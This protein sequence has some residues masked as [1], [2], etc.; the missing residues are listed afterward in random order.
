MLKCQLIGKAF[1]MLC[2]VSVLLT[3]TDIGLTSVL[4]TPTVDN[5]S[6]ENPTGLDRT[7]NHTID[8]SGLT[9]DGSAGST[10]DQGENS[11]VWTTSGV[12]DTTDYD[13]YITYDLGGLCDVTKMRIW[14]YNS[15]Y[16]VGSPPVNITIIGPNEVDVY[17][18]AN[19][20]SFTFAETVNFTE[21]SGTSGYP[22]QDITVDY[23]SVRYIKFDIMTNHDGAVFDGTGSN[24][25]A[26]DGRSLTGLSEVRFEALERVEINESD[27][28]TVVY[29]GGDGDSYDIV[30]ARQPAPDATVEITA[31]P[32]KPVIRLN[33]T[34]SGEPVTLIFSDQNWNTPQTVV[35]MAVDDDV[36]TT[37]N[38]SI[39]HTSSSSGDPAFDNLGIKGVSIIYL[40]N[41]SCGLWGYN[42][43]DFNRDCRV[44]ISDFAIFA[45][46]WFECS[47]PSAP[48][49]V[50]LL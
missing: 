22:G 46:Q 17:T 29:E 35:V 1:T 48:D 9:G 32:S 19:G 7:A 49:C 4:V 24:G 15:A 34:S 12:Y 26:A 43:I 39:N 36:L 41:D 3:L 50:N 18:S 44:D 30:L 13:P 45:S 31:T 23:P 2:L 40:D 28:T 11:I 8:G 37:Q 38:P 20:T 21:A 10:H 25:G 16:Q 47:Q 14:N 42:R 6:S 5:F 33:G 27:G